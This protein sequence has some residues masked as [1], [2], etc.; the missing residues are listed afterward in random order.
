[1]FIYCLRVNGVR[2]VFNQAL[3]FFSKYFHDMHPWL[4]KLT[5]Y[6][7]GARV[8]RYIILVHAWGNKFFN[9]VDTCKG[10]F[11]KKDSNTKNK[12]R[13]DYARLLI[14][15]PFLVVINYFEDSLIDDQL[16]GVK[17][18][19]ELRYNLREDSFLDFDDVEPIVMNRNMRTSLGDK[20]IT[21]VDELVQKLQEEFVKNGYEGSGNKCGS[22]LYLGA[23]KTN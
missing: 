10:N 20:N 23:S 3:E 6:E 17:M 8:R 4:H 5:V 11:L 1:M 21:E 14:M 9:L 12:A 13:F 2:F 16:Y 7:R 15:A 19:E 22:C 18:V